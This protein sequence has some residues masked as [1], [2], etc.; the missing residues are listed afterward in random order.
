MRNFLHK[1]NITIFGAGGGGSN[2]TPPPPN[3]SQYPSILTPPQFS[4]VNT[5][6]SF[7]Y[8]EMIDLISDGPIE[9]LVNKNGKKV[10]DENIFEGIYLNDTPIKQTSSEKKQTI[11]IEF[12]KLK[13]KKHFKYLNNS[14]NTFLIENQKRVSTIP[15]NEIDDINF[16]SDITITSYHPKNSIFEFVK[17]IEGSFDSISL[18]Q[19]AFDLSPIINE[20][21]F[22]TIINIPKFIINLSKDRFDITE[23]GENSPSPLKIGMIDLSNYIYFTIASETLN[24]FNYFEL[25]R[26]FI[27]NNSLTSFGKKTFKKN[28]IS[29]DNFYSYEIYDTNIYIWSIYNE[30]VGIKDID[31]VLD[32]YFNNIFIFQN[33]LSL[34][35]YN[36]V[37]SEFKNGSEVQAPLK[38]FANVEI[39]TEY[40]K[41]LIGPFKVS[42]SFNPKSA[43]E[44]GGVQRI[45]SFNET[46][47]YRPPSLTV[48]NIDNETSDDIRYVT[49]WPIEYNCKGGPFLICCAKL[50]YSQFDKN[51]ASRVAQDAVPITHY[52]NNDNV[53]EIYVTINIDQLYDTNH[54]DLVAD[55]SAVYGAGCQ[56]KI[57]QTEIIS[58]NLG[59]NTYGDIVGYNNLGYTSGNIYFLIYGTSYLN[60]YV[61]DGFKTT[62]ELTN[63]NLLICNLQRVV[64]KN[65]PNTLYYNVISPDGLISKIPTIK[66]LIGTS[67]NG[68]P[69][70]KASLSNN[71]INYQIPND[72]YLVRESFTLDS[73]NQISLLEAKLKNLNENQ[74][75]LFC[76]GLNQSEVITSTSFSQYTLDSNTYNYLNSA[77]TENNY[78]F[79]VSKLSYRSASSKE[80]SLK[81]V[82]AHIIND[83]INWNLLID[84]TK[85]TVWIPSQNL[86][87]TI[88]PNIYKYIINPYLSLNSLKNGTDF[89]NYKTD[90]IGNLYLVGINGSYLRSQV[91]FFEDSNLQYLK[92]NILDQLLEDFLLKTDQ[93]S[94]FKNIDLND[95][96]NYISDFSTTRALENSLF[97]FEN[98][99]LIG[100]SSI[101]NFRK[102]TINNIYYTT[103]DS[104]PSEFD[105]NVINEFR[106]LYISKNIF[107]YRSQYVSINTTDKAGRDVVFF[108]NLYSNINLNTIQTA[109]NSD[110]KFFGTNVQSDGTHS[111]YDI[112]SN[113]LS[114]LTQ[115]V[116]AGTKLPAIV[117]ID[118]ETGYESKEDEQYRG[119]CEYFSYR[120]NIYGIAN[121]AAAIDL[122]RKSYDFVSACKRSLDRGGYTSSYRN[123]YIENYPIYFFR[124][125]C[126]GVSSQKTGYYLS[127][128]KDLFLGNINLNSI[129]E[130]TNL[131]IYYINCE[132][133][134]V[135]VK[136][137]YM[138]GLTSTLNGVTTCTFNEFGTID[139]VYKDI[140]SI[141]RTNSLKEITYQQSLD[142]FQNNYE[143]LN[144]GN[145]ISF[146]KD[147]INNIITAELNPI[148]NYIISNSVNPQNINNYDS[149][150]YIDDSYEY[151]KITLQVYNYKTCL[152]KSVYVD[153]NWITTSVNNVNYLNYDK[154]ISNQIKAIDKTIYMYVYVDY[155]SD[156]ELSYNS[157]FNIL[158]KNLKSDLILQFKNFVVRFT[159]TQTADSS[160]TSNL[161]T[162]FELFYGTSLTINEKIINTNIFPQDLTDILLSNIDF[163]SQEI[164]K[165]FSLD[166]NAFLSR[167]VLLN[168]INSSSIELDFYNSS[169]L[170]QYKI[171][172]VLTRNRIILNIRSLNYFLTY[173]TATLKLSDKRFELQNSSSVINPISV[174]ANFWVIF[175][176]LIGQFAIIFKPPTRA[177]GYSELEEEIEFLNFSN[178]MGL[179][180]PASGPVSWSISCQSWYGDTA[181]YNGSTYFY[182]KN[183]G[184]INF[185]NNSYALIKPRNSYYLLAYKPIENCI[186]ELVPRYWNGNSFGGE[187]YNG[188]DAINHGGINSNEYYIP[189]SFPKSWP[190]SDSSF[191]GAYFD[192]PSWRTQ[193]T[194]D[195]KNFIDNISIVNTSSYPNP[196]K[197]K[198]NITNKD[199]LYNQN[200]KITLCNPE[201]NTSAE[202]CYLVTTYKPNSTT[203]QKY[204][205]Y[206]APSNWLIEVEKNLIAYGILQS[207]MRLETRSD[208]P[209]LNDINWKW[210]QVRYY[211]QVQVSNTFADLGNTL[212]NDAGVRI[213][214]PQPKKD[215]YGNPI[216]RYVKITRKSHESLSVLISKKISLNKV[217]EIIPQKFSYP[218]SAIVG[219]K[220]DSRAF[221]QI[222]N[223]TFLC[224][225]KK[226]LIPSNYFPNDENEQDVRYIQGNGK[227]KIYDGDWDGTFKLAWSNNP[228]WVMLDLLVNKRY[229]LGNYIESD[230]VDI[231][232]LYKIAR[233]C[234]CVDDN[235]Y[236]YGVSDGFG[237]VEP[238]HSFNGLISDKFNIFDMINQVASVFRG[239][240]YYMN[241]LITFDDDRIK[242]IIGQ[243]NNSEVKDGLFNYTNHKKDD[244]FTAV[245]VAY[246]DARDNFKPKI[247][248]VEDSDGIRQRGILKKQVNTFGITSVAQARRFGKY[249]LYQTSKE[250]STVSFITDS[251]ALLY[252]PGD[253]IKINDE[254]MNS[255]KN[256]GEIKLI[257][258]I[259]LDCFKIVIDKLMDSKIYNTG[260]ITIY[261]PVAK[262]K[263]DDFYSNAQ[264]VPENL[265]F[266]TSSALLGSL[267]ETFNKEI[268][269][270]NNF[271]YNGIYSLYTNDPYV[272]FEMGSFETKSS[273]K[274]FSGVSNV[275]YEITTGNSNI[276][277]YITKNITG[278]LTYIQNININNESSKYGYWQFTIGS[279]NEDQDKILFDVLQNESIKY[280]LPYKNYFF[281][282][283]DTGRYLRYSGVNDFGNIYNSID[284]DPRIESVWKNLPNDL[285]HTGEVKKSSL[286]KFSI[287]NY[288]KPSL[289][290]TQI[291][292]NDRPSIDTFKIINFETGSCICNNII[293][294]EYTELILSKQNYN[295]NFDGARYKT[296][297]ANNLNNI[298]AGYPYSLTINN[299]K[300]KIYKINSISENYINEYN[301]IAS[302]YNLDKFKEIEDNYQ[303]DDLKTTFN[304][305]NAYTQSIDSKTSREIQAP[306]IKS[307]KYISN[308]KGIEIKW[309]SVVNANMYDIFI[310]TP[311]KQ[312]NNF[313]ATASYEQDFNKE[314]NYF[315]KVWFLPE[316]FEIGT[317][318]ISI[319]A[320]STFNNTNSINLVSPTS[321]R[322]INI[323]TY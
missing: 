256:Y 40:G 149:Y 110:I 294:N 122:G 54:I 20:R 191:N 258:D 252:K 131:Q 18:I 245:D 275:R 157:I 19:K 300:S 201:K 225:L 306:V 140:T 102:N 273:I 134:N 184:S 249:F 23:G 305:L 208:T 114:K 313:I 315:E 271:Y 320:Y 260:E 153:P 264:F 38:Y 100:N 80:L 231:W 86:D 46:F 97:K 214:I 170:L 83:Y 130:N 207:D 281:E 148:D 224:K 268:I 35:N 132:N 204:G 257:D 179:N 255:I 226:I 261:S 286:F 88:Y 295:N 125:I 117:T 106:T 288:K 307:L 81:A 230:Q 291:I 308:I 240:V 167:D 1:K 232:E 28:L 282:Y 107:L 137:I 60:G 238:R 74:T 66:D 52:I 64:D 111:K 67:L 39:D 69:I 297:T 76:F 78:K 284:F 227:Y 219:T 309:N 26:S 8:A 127:N 22:L 251:R 180:A 57:N 84:K 133:S 186:Y 41:E 143:C 29:S 241:S 62:G 199:Y 21:P 312:T 56:S 246:I 33:D 213:Q 267:K 9:G 7:S 17:S 177:N 25:P 128:K 95:G 47:S 112:N 190:Y 287:T 145:A 198:I 173:K 6:S 210:L 202:Y 123:V 68:S 13:L 221:S 243:F 152:Y 85:T 209:I 98:G 36:L 215:K 200:R 171:L 93:S 280:Q 161:K 182:Y 310:Q 70:Y 318:T 158:S 42:G 103:F 119:A 248:Y 237:G 176:K 244:E 314:N 16:K 96:K 105:K 279:T 272:K 147:P 178:I 266:C 169:T 94:N 263:Y 120:Y 4:N 302:E 72:S 203:T 118:V 49:S 113:C 136:Q 187:A 218:F 269:G 298:H 101:Y 51:T 44:A 77:V 139:L 192:I 30:E 175:N 259:N 59:V 233:W 211:S 189:I 253:L 322:S 126:S 239:H 289:S 303:V 71:L 12:L 283:F 146:L 234:D 229:G 193:I 5:I 293:Y 235:G 31:N 321:S 32:K 15:Q 109:Q 323:M 150:E 185:S 216:R 311:S 82:V 121:Q 217:T 316:N 89:A 194:Y 27:N 212:A 166:S 108:Y 151:K 206:V 142:F 292:E 301:L 172:K 99:K 188:W 91:S 163:I 116:T 43:F 274:S 50:N 135:G 228:A 156:D 242:P 299:N 195:G 154:I 34:F 115:T 92:L 164:N 222:P 129:E 138:T 3:I 144:M 183:N 165:K 319:Q 168:S 159:L 205:S 48:P 63:N 174:N 247:E 181:T 276:A 61:I 79:F 90:I 14:I 196:W 75:P 160:I 141:T 162:I 220:I 24:S 197:Q 265:I 45:K 73:F 2:S 296:S 37:Q 277:G 10:Y 270:D 53:E 11:P 304:F 250:N 236:Y 290:Y 262:P 58:N 278:Y 104:S 254:L 317:Y 65:N 124:L 285:N 55:N 155:F 87:E 223:R